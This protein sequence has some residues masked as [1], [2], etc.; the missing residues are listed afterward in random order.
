MMHTHKFDLND[1]KPDSLN[2]VLTLSLLMLSIGW[3]GCEEPT[4]R[5]DTAPTM[6]A[7]SSL[8]QGALNPDRP[9]DLRMSDVSAHDLSRPDLGERS[10][11]MHVNLDHSVVSDS[12]IVDATPDATLNA[13][14]DARLTLLR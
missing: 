2:S 3:V 7:D 5:R 13:T 14:P 11:D 10:L 9:L 12:D 1:E 6:M 4:P 8:D